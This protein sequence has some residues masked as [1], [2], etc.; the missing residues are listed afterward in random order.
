MLAH[1]QTPSVLVTLL[2]LFVSVATP[3]FPSCL[4]VLCVVIYTTFTCQAAKKLCHQCNC[5][6][7]HSATTRGQWDKNIL[8][9]GHL[10]RV[11]S[12]GTTLRMNKQI[13]RRNK[14]NKWTLYIYSEHTLQSFAAH[15]ELQPASDMPW[16]PYS[17]NMPYRLSDVSGRDWADDHRPTDQLTSMLKCYYL[18][19]REGWALFKH[20]SLPPLICSATPLE[21][22][23]ASY[24]YHSLPG[25]TLTEEA[26]FPKDL[27]TMH[28]P[29]SIF[30]YF[31]RKTKKKK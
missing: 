10:S 27:V 9:V 23:K 21:A 4:S 8:L 13:N 26:K 7:V 2:L 5:V 16:M 14:I 11:M 29:D 18:S 15:L 17:S 25:C 19:S 12:T 1:L 6:S 20:P 3:V 30:K 28:P 22:I 31:L 24:L